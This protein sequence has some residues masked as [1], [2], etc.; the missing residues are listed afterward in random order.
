MEFAVLLLYYFITC[1]KS[2]RIQTWYNIFIIVKECSFSSSLS[3][4]FLIL[5][6]FVNNRDI[7]LVIWSKFHAPLVPYV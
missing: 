1:M 4:K 2:V 6:S 3:S 7:F 5:F